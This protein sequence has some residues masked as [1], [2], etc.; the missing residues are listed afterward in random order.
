[1]N[2][3]WST[4]CHFFTPQNINSWPSSVHPILKTEIW[5]MGEFITGYFLGLITGIAGFWKF[6]IIMVSSSNITIRCLNNLKFGFIYRLKFKKIKREWEAHHFQPLQLWAH[7]ACGFWSPYR[8]IHCEYSIME[9][10]QSSS[11]PIFIFLQWI[12]TLWHNVWI[13]VNCQ[14]LKLI[15]Y[16]TRP[17]SIV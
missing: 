15:V 11:F 7:G 3:W 10:I 5:F 13:V 2:S 16:V 9:D 14:C 4:I 17:Y 1:M 12:P 6:C 8:R